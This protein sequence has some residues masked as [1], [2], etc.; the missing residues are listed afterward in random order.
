MREPS[1]R[2]LEAVIEGEIDAVTSA[3]VIQEIHHRFTALGDRRRGAAMAEAALDIFAPVLPIAE[4]VMRR[5][6]DLV[7]SLEGLSARDLVHVATC[8]EARI[9]VIV[10]P[11]HGFDQVDGLARFDPLEVDQLL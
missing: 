1:R 9:E 10:S 7:L 11:D 8:A 2:L 4:A 6:T 5:M 3:E